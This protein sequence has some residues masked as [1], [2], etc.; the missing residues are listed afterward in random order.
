VTGRLG[1]VA[2]SGVL[3][4]LAG[5]H[6]AWGRGST[7]PFTSREALNDTVIGGDT[8]PPPAAC[9][10]VATLLAAAGALVAGLP[11]RSSWIRRA[12]VCAVATTLGGRAALGFAGK[13]DVVSP[14]ST[15]AHFR[16][17]DRC[18]YSPLCLALALGAL[19]SLRRRAY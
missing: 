4:A 18:Y 2:T 10:S 1:T 14:G 12:G 6:V 15:S 19:D 5:L 9:Y 11:T 17:I 3:A 16:R 7:F 13:T 8:T